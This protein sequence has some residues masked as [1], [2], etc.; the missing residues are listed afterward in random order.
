MSFSLLPYSISIGQAF[1]FVSELYEAK[2][3]PLS[4]AYTVLSGKG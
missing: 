4:I 3:D 1:V 2:Y